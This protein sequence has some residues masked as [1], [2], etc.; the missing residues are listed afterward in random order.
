M[1]KYTIRSRFELSVPETLN[2]HEEHHDSS[3]MVFGR[4]YMQLNDSAEQ[5][6]EENA[7]LSTQMLHLES[8][9]S[10]GINHYSIIQSWNEAPLQE[11]PNQM[12]GELS[13]HV[14]TILKDRYGQYPEDSA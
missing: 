10:D 6:V 11:V 2:P 7:Y 13:Y 9:D 8:T 5:L 4:I 1:A 12:V 14:K 3:H